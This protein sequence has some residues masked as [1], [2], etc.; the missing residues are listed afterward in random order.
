MVKM[1]RPPAVYEKAARGKTKFHE[2]FIATGRARWIRSGRLRFMPE[3]VLDRLLAE[4][5]AAADAEPV[6]P[7]EPALPY[8]AMMRGARSRRK[9]QSKTT[10]RKRAEA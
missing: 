5:I 4:D 6:E 3:H 2:D 9:H 1:L 8:D 7:P 10:S